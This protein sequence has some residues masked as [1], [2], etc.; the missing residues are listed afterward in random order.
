MMK[1][2]ECV[3]KFVNDMLD[4]GL[5][6]KGVRANSCQG[7]GRFFVSYNTPICEFTVGRKFRLA[8]KK[9]SV[10]TSKQQNYLRFFIPSDML[11]EV[12]EIK[13]EKF[14]FAR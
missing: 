7:I 9:Y 14:P 6:S 1:T 3:A 8:T 13:S 11:E 2:R 5:V 10:T 12:V 4:F